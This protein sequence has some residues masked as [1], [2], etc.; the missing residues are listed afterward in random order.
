MEITELAD[1]EFEVLSPSGNHYTV[2]YEG[3]GDGDPDYIALW[4][5]T[6][7]AYRFA[8]A[9]RGLCKHINAVVALTDEN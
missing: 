3:S 6:C 2:R 7:P 4:S 1:G 5:C 9:G 8:R